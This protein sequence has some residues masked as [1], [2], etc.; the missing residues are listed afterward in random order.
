MSIRQMS[1]E[2]GQALNIQEC[3]RLA[4]KDTTFEE[5]EKLANDNI[6]L[7]VK[8]G[9]SYYDVTKK[10]EIFEQAHDD[11][12]LGSLTKMDQ[13]DL[14]RTELAPAFDEPIQPDTDPM[15]LLFKNTTPQ[16]EEGVDELERKTYYLRLDQ[17]ETL[18]TICFKEDKDVSQVVR[19]LLDIGITQKSELHGFDFKTDSEQKILTK[20]RK[21]KRKNRKRTQ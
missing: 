1:F 20:P 11:F 16:D 10:P 19:E 15:A 18:R 14:R 8:S 6:F 13:R 17:I 12:N 5:L 4:P 7:I 9:K 21:P 3:P 2:E